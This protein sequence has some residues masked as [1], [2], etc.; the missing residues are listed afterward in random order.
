MARHHGFTCPKCGSHMFGTH[1]HHSVMGDKYPHG[2][3]V[4]KCQGYLHEAS[5]CRYEWRR[6]DAS[7]EAEC[8]YEQTPQEWMEAHQAFVRE[9]KQRQGSTGQ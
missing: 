4:G 9:I 5:D 2:A 6:D 8:M 7:A 3:S 1:M